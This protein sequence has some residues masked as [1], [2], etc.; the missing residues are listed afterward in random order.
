MSI[1][2]PLHHRRTDR[3]GGITVSEEPIRQSLTIP[4]ELQERLSAIKQERFFDTSYSEMYRQLIML[5][6]EQMEKKGAAN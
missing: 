4:P 1:G 6:L 5:G 2:S 3:K